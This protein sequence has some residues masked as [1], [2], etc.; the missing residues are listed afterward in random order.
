MQKFDRFGSD[1]DASTSETNFSFNPKCIFRNFLCLIFFL[2]LF[3]AFQFS[4]PAQSLIAHQLEVDCQESLISDQNLQFKILFKEKTLS[5]KE[6]IEK[7]QQEAK[8]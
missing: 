2:L 6:I 4:F 7:L 8:Q 1:D 5:K 3:F